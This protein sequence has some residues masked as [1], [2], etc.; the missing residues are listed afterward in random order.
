MSATDSRTGEVGAGSG[1][2]M[3]RRYIG[4][5]VDISG[6]LVVRELDVAGRGHAG[7]EGGVWGDR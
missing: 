6:Q 1:C 2:G 3:S 5:E 7:K 4:I